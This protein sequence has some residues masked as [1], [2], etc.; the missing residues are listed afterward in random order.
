MA[1]DYR[2]E[3]AARK[4]RA[5]AKG[6]TYSRER[7]RSEKQSAVA[8]G[9]DSVKKA[10]AAGRKLSAGTTQR[11]RGAQPPQVVQTRGLTIVRLLT[12]ADL[13]K[14]RQLLRGAGDTTAVVI[15]GDVQGRSGPVR[16]AMDRDA[17]YV[18]GASLRQILADLEDQAAADYGGSWT[19][20]GVS[21]VQ[22]G[23]GR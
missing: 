4:A 22:A 14:L 6:T 18:R 20:A 16:V 17:A 5:A 10:R 12:P 23:F 19:A 3:Y 9:F 1:R 11:T 8:Q 15:Q 21:N 7:Y 13:G 2:A